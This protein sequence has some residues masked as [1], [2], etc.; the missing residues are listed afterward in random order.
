MTEIIL[1]QYPTS[2]YGE[3][4]RVALGLKGLP[5]RKVE[6]PSIM[7]RPHLT[8]LTG[9]YRRIPVMQIGADIYCDTGIILREIDRRFPD[10]PLTSPSVTGAVWALRNW[11]ERAWFAATVAIV[12]GARGESVPQEFIKDREALSGRP[13]DIGALKAAAPMMRGQWRANAELMDTQLAASGP[14]MFGAQASAA[15]LAVYLNI[16]FLQGGEPDAFAK[17]TTGLSHLNAWKQ[18][19]AAFGH[20]APIEMSAAEAFEI[21][22]AAAP[23]TPRASLGD[24]AQGLTPGMQVAVMPDDYGR[25]PVNGEIV[26][27][28]P[29]EIAIRRQAEGAGDVVVH[30]PRAGF[31]VMPAA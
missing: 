27:V 10:P 28:S 25:N 26:F 3:M 18:R 21:A 24:D 22:V 31:L 8:P 11:A 20:G 23:E 17:L 15:D 30:F 5:W 2:P 6:Q 12:F 7:P 14:F 29:Q 9:G 19:M 1:H 16:W 4:V 13:F